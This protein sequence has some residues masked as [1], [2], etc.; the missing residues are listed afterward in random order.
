MQV[1]GKII[2]G[3]CIKARPALFDFRTQ[4]P[5]FIFIQIYQ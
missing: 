2:P 5:N 4:T 3:T 1:P